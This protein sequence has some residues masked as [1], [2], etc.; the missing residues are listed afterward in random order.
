M[1]DSGPDA[2]GLAALEGVAEFEG[3]GFDAEEAG[4]EFVAGGRG[5]VVGHGYF[6]NVS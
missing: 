6:S 5:G 4:G 2:V 3:S 1:F